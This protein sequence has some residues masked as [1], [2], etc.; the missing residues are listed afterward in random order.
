MRSGLGDVQGGL[1]EPGRVARTSGLL[2]RPEARWAALTSWGWLPE[3]WGGA[4]KTLRGLLGWVCGW[5]GDLR[6]QFSMK[7]CAPEIRHCH[8]QP[9]RAALGKGVGD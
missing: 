5:T 6:S 4:Q 7:G 1:E 3:Q 2:T 9:V 8:L